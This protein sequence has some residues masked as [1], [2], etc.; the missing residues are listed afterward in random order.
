MLVAI[1]IDKGRP[2]EAATTATEIHCATRSLGSARVRRKLTEAAGRL[3]PHRRNGEVAA[4]LGSCRMR[5]VSGDEP[6][7]LRDPEA[8]RAYLEA[9]EEL[10]VDWPGGPLLTVDWVVPHGPWDDGLV[11]LFDGG[12]LTQPIRLDDDEI[13]GYRFCTMEHSRELLRPG[14]FDRVWN[15]GAAYLHNGRP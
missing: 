10:P 6:L 11:S 8:Y 7:Y 4:F 13:G 9:R 1:A 3:A 5:R 12:V 15:A 14:T 2:D